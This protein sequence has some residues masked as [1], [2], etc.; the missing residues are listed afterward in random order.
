MDRSVPAL[1]R[2]LFATQGKIYRQLEEEIAETEAQL[3]QWHRA[4]ERARRFARCQ[5]NPESGPKTARWL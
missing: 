4:D 1:A 2:T 5:N 3:A